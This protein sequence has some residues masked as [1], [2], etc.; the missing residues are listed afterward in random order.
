VS[1]VEGTQAVPFGQHLDISGAPAWNGGAPLSLLPPLVGRQGAPSVAEGGNGG[2]RVAFLQLNAGNAGLDAGLKRVNSTGAP[3]GATS[4]ISYG[5]GP[6]SP[7]TLVKSG[8]NQAIAL[9]T[10]FSDLPPTLRAQRFSPGGAPQWGPGGLTL[11]AGAPFGAFLQ[12]RIPATPDGQGGVLVGWWSGNDIVVQR[13]DSTSALLWGAGGATVFQGVYGSFLPTEQSVQPDGNGGAF[14]V[15]LVYGDSLGSPVP[16]WRVQKLDGAG[17]PLWGTNGVEFANG[18]LT[19]D[20]FSAYI[21]PDASGGV[22]AVWQVG[23]FTDDPV[24]MIRVQHFQSTGE[25]VAGWPAEGILVRGPY[26]AGVLAGLAPDGLGNVVV[27]WMEFRGGHIGAYAQLVTAGG[28][29]QWNGP[30]ANTTNGSINQGVSLA[31]T[32]GP[33][34]LPLVQTDDSGGAVFAWIEGSGNSWDILAQRITSDG[35]RAWGSSGLAV[36][37]A[38]GQQ[39]DI[40]LAPDGA[41][42]ALIAW[43]DGRYAP[44]DQILMARVA[45]NG[46]L[47]WAGNGVVSTL[48]SLQSA[49]VVNGV[50]RLA[51]TTRESSLRA[52]LERRTEGSAWASLGEVSSDGIGWIR[53]EDA[54]VVRGTRYGYRLVA[55]ANGAEEPLGEVWLDVPATLAFAVHGVRPNPANGPLTVSFALPRNAPATLEI[56]DVAGRRVLSREVGTLGAGSHVLNLGDPA[57]L[58]MGLYFLRITQGDEQRQA[59]FTR[60][61]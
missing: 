17:N 28:L 58:G 60:I 11:T 43:A 26:L 3:Q 4:P 30:L 21:T 20:L 24:H 49:A 31:L 38:A 59:R 40:A 16:S 55:R 54:T 32:N 9:W 33:Q 14:V 50:A 23:V 48:A 36:C 52:R 7:V 2:A 41:S 25:I 44:T 12:D 45:G 35:A 22:Y 19:P 37:N 61:R 56:L 42:G 15:G 57:G 46:S 18:L 53:A 39:G 10:E 27:C 47:P 13:V 29:L 34:V 51:W 5:S 8:A 6:V 1:S